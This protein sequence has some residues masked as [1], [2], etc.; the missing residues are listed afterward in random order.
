MQ[1]K[2]AYE[3]AGELHKRQLV[4]QQALDDAT[5]MRSSRRLTR[6]CRTEEPPPTSTRRRER[7]AR[8][9]SD[10]RHQHPRT[11]EGYIQ[12]RMV[13]LGE[14]VKNQTPVMSVV[15]VDPLKVIAEIPERMAPWIQVGQ[16]VELRVDAFPDKSI[17]GTVSRISPAVNAQTRAFAFEARVPNPGA[18]LKPGTFARVHIETAK[19]DNILTLPYNSLQY[20]YGVSRV[21]VVAADKLSARELKLGDRVGDRIEIVSGVG[22]GDQ[23]AVSDVDVLADGM[24]VTAKRGTE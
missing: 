6:R 10:A 22:V 24:K 21:F 18:L 12:K 9:S 13:S 16:P 1:A 17:T 14:F 2:Q 15:R 5:T 20:R 7:E 4:P 23:V 3:R 19:I 8:R 11:F